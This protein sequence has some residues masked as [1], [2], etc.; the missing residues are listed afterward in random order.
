VSALGDA[1]FKVGRFN[2]ARGYFEELA[3]KDPAG[4]FGRRAL[5]RL[6]DFPR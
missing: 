4:P 2:E 6:R 3:R 1:C 5:E